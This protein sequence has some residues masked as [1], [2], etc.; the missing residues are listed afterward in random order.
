MRVLQRITHTGLRPEVHH[1]I[2]LLR[3]KQLDGYP[4][5][6][7]PDERSRWPFTLLALR[8]TKLPMSVN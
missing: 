2:E 8:L 3:T 6:R 7:L 4:P 5:L 1:T